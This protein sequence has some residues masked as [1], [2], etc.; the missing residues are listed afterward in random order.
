MQFI[1]AGYDGRDAEALNHLL[2]RWASESPDT[3]AHA[4]CKAKNAVGYAG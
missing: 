2:S 3:Q 1:V 4:E